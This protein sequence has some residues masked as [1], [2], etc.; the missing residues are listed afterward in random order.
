[1][2]A[3]EKWP[4]SKAETWPS[5]EAAWTRAGVGSRAG[6]VAAFVAWLREEVR[7]ETGPGRLVPWL[8]VA[9]GAG[10]ALYFTAAHEPVVWVTVLAAATLSGFAYAV[11]HRR[12]FAAVGLAAAL[13]AG[14]AAAT[15]KAALVAHPV[16]DKP[17]Y[18]SSLTGFIEA[19]EV[20]QSTDRIVLRV[21][22]I[23]ARGAAP[24]LTRVRLAVRKGTAP[25]VGSFIEVKAR[26]AP[27]LSPLQPGGYDFA[28][29]LYFQGIGAS[30]FVLGAITQRAP[31]RQ[32]G[33]RLGYAAA[34]QGMRDAIDARIRAVL[35]GDTRAIATALITGR[36]DAITPAVNDAMFVSGLGHILSISGYHMA[37]AA[38]VVF[39]ALRLLLAAIPALAGFPVKKTA[40]A[41]ALLAAAFYLLLSGAEVA[42]QRSFL[43]T[44]VVL[45]AVMVDRRA[46]TVRTLAVAA[47]AV[48]LLAPEALVHPSFQ[49]SFAATLALVVL[50]E[51]GM[52]RLFL[53]ADSSLTARAALWGGREVLTLAAASLVAGL[54]TTPYAA[55][56]F[57]R[58]APY[59][60]LANLAAMPVVSGLVMP[61]GLV[62]LVAAPFGLDG[63]FWHLMGVGIEWMVWIAQRVAALPG[64]VG[65]VPAFGTGA[66]LAMTAGILMLGLLRTRLR[67]AGLAVLAA[68]IVWAMA[69]SRPDI[70]VA[71]DG[72]GVAVRGTDGRLRIMRTGNDAFAVR[73]WL[74]ADADARAAD[75]PSL[76]AGVSCDEIGCVVA[77]RG[78]GLV[79]LTLRAEAFADDC[80]RAAVIVTPHPPPSACGAL[81]VD[82]GRLAGEGA[83]ALRAIDGGFAVDA[84]RPRGS[85]RP[86]YAR[87]SDRADVH[88]MRSRADAPAVDATPPVDVEQDVDDQ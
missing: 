64:A 24:Q 30:G 48:L 61:A 49:M 36:R 19:K 29:D 53:S 8:P 52:P 56:H 46:I 3:R 15:S 71:Q 9:F 42:T 32:G 62:G 65:R 23:Q 83:L 82:A 38:G 12:A 33:L 73:D 35:D 45:I 10:I 72:R 57:H 31:P 41:G 47:L 2:T 58:L 81:V 26:L 43:M 68:G 70:V 50:V 21:S 74:A 51:F 78:A 20:R 40:A 14:F 34:M 55:F 69:A 39:F 80:A 86:W 84:A 85:L 44:A 1:M 6:T 66:L 88:A 27:P 22:D 79:A 75:D 5:G 77:M 18:A 59:G 37:V 17:I 67:L 63:P 4:R 28:R 13:A 7:A 60:V 11:R 54:A 25:P 16:L 76:S 87:P